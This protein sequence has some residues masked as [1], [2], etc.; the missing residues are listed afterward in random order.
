[1]GSY[2]CI[3]ILVCHLKEPLQKSTTT[4]SHNVI[5]MWF[6]IGVKAPGMQLWGHGFGS[7]R[8]ELFSAIFCFIDIGLSQD[9]RFRNRNWELLPEHG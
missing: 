7:T 9:Y 8:G 2:I 5:L 4:I 1:M 3:I 6:D